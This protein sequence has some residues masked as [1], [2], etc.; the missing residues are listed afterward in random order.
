MLHIWKWGKDIQLKEDDGKT[1][2]YYYLCEANINEGDDTEGSDKDIE[3]I[4]G[5]LQRNLVRL[6]TT[7]LPN[8]TLYSCQDLLFNSIYSHWTLLELHGQSNAD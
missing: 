6:A 2:Y 1:Y 8:S 3:D 4:E 7:Y 5:D